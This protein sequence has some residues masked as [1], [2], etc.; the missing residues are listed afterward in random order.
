QKRSLLLSYKQAQL[1]DYKDIFGYYPILLFD[2][3]GS[4]LDISR[5][6]NIFDKILD[7]S[8]QIFITTTDAP[9]SKKNK[10]KILEVSEG[11]FSEFIFD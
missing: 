4:E 3:I 11:D 2:D 6:E 5:K 7:N 1:L 10:N 9:D 8:G